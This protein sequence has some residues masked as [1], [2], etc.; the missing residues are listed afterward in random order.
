[1]LLNPPLFCSQEISYELGG[2]G[3]IA[4]MTRSSSM[5]SSPHSPSTPS[6]IFGSQPAASE[7]GGWG[8]GKDRCG[9]QHTVQQQSHSTGNLRPLD[10]SFWEANLRRPRAGERV[11]VKQRCC[12]AT[13]RTPRYA[14]DRSSG[15]RPICHLLRRKTKVRRGQHLK[16]SAAFTTVLQFPTVESGSATRGAYY[17]QR[18]K[19]VRK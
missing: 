13:A 9:Q 5:P 17:G 10:A 3:R 2:T 8:P 1:M 14:M 12:R 11:Q 4:S 6:L 7:G 15:R 18:N 19:L 16:A